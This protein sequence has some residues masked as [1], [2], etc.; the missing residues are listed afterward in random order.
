MT[1]HRTSGPDGPRPVTTATGSGA[2]HGVDTGGMNPQIVSN[3]ELM[4]FVDGAL[5]D[6]GRVRVLTHLASRPEAVG[7]VEAYLHQNANL[8][9]LREHLPL[10]DSATFAAPLQAAI[11]ESLSRRQRQRTWR[12]IAVAATVLL[13][14]AGGV[15]GLALQHWQEPTQTAAA[16]PA[17]AYFLFEQHDV[18]IAIDPD[19]ALAQAPEIDL[20]AFAWLADRATNVTISAPDLHRVGLEL[21]D[22][23]V[24]DQQGAPAIRAVYRDAAGKP[25]VLFAGIG[26]PDVQHAF[27]L[28][29]E[30]YISLQ[31]RRGP[32]I[33]A[34]VAPTD[35]PQLSAIVDLVGAA[36]AAIVL[37]EQEST[38]TGAGGEPTLAQPAPVEAAPA[39][40]GPL[41]SIALPAAPVVEPPGD[42][43]TVA[44]PDT[45]K[46]DT[47]SETADSNTPESL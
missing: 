41:Q 28:E 45:V 4:R 13:A 34:L 8:R 24:L 26:K 32:M 12:R 16:A 10:G 44:E 29:R 9:L 31:W 7:R 19:A 23:E 43:A 5:D 3:D 40:T 22:G 46:A 47:V 6:D 33:F 2:R 21:I 18:G 35:S 1:K 27:W 14:L 15:G 39:E 38:G 17:Q 25:V 11:V 37:P 30:G 20:T 42:P 36:V